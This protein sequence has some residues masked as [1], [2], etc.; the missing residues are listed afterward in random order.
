MLY[1]ALV[2]D[3]L[4]TCIITCKKLTLDQ[5][6]FD[7][8]AY[9]LLIVKI[10]SVE[11]YYECYWYTFEILTAFTVEPPTV[12]NEL[13]LSWK[14]PQRRHSDLCMAETSVL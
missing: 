2:T 12:N 14:P 7:N 9:P 6:H 1:K 4:A 5:T 13:P 10:M 11:Q 3:E 8:H